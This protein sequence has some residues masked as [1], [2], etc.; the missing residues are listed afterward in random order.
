MNKF[1]IY[2]GLI[3]LILSHK[4]FGQDPQFSQFYANPVYLSPSF[5]GSTD[6]TRAVL[7]FRDQWPAMPGAFVTFA[8][9]LDHYFPRYNSG[10]G[11]QFITDRAGSGHLGLTTVSVN[12]SYKIKL[13]RRWI[14]QPGL[15]L[16]YNQR[17]IDFDKLRF[18]NQMHIDGNATGNLVK[19]S[20][21]K[22]QY[23]DAG[24]SIFAY[25]KLY[26]GG[27]MIDHIFNPNQALLNDGIARV[28]V[29][30]R[31]YGGRKFVVSNAKRYNQET[32]KVAFNYKAQGRFDQLD[33]GAY[34]SRD[35]FMFGLWYRG[36]PLFKSYDNDHI[37]H[38]A[39]VVLFGYK[40]K[41]LSIA[42]SYDVT[43]SRMFAHTN[44]SHEI[45]LI[46]LFNQN[47]KVRRKRKAIII[48]CPKF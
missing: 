13:T 31:L 18:N 10:V 24:F 29:K 44:G 11:L 37:N 19:P 33:I 36:I 30:F 47:Q 34:W 38:D 12:Y 46:F 32:I 28:P 20:L 23:G 35:P 15:M 48:P 41:E 7:N 16:N 27:F 26:W 21:D 43:I 25:N 39:F 6:G 14:V 4:S 8:A 3:L 9:S 22:V 45:S 2:I 42:Y 17:S 40:Y 1:A 5:A